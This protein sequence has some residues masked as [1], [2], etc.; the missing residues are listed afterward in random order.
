M[1]VFALPGPYGIGCFSEEA[2][3]FADFLEEAGQHYWQIL[4]LGPTGYGDSP[5]SPFSTFAGNPYFIDLQYFVRN[6]LLTSA[7]CRETFVGREDGRIDYG[8]LYRTRVPLM[9]EAY[10]RWKQTG[11]RCRD[12]DDYYVFREENACWL[13][14]YAL[15]MA[16]K[17]HYG[18][19]SIDS[20]P[21]E[22]RERSPGALMQAR[23]ELDEEV[24][25]QSFVQY[26][27]EKQWMELKAYVNSKGIRIIGDIPIYVSSDSADFWADSRLFIKGKDGGKAP[28][29]GVPPD[30]FSATGQLW[31]N[32]LYDW[33]KHR[34]DGYSWWLERIGRCAKI[35][36]VLRI[37]HF[38]G[39]DEYFC[40]PGDADSAA[41]GHWEKGPGMDL[42]RHVKA[43]YPRLNII[44]E[45]LGYMSD[46]VK[47]L[48]SDTG[49]PNMKVLEFAFDSR[50]VGEKEPHMPHAY[51]S[52][53]VAYTGTHDNET[54]IQWLGSIRPA[55]KEKLMDYVGAEPG[56][57]LQGIAWK[58]IRSLQASHAELCV[59][60]AWDWI[61][62]GAEARIN[63]PGSSSG[64]WTWRAAPDAFDSTLAA[65][66]RHLCRTY[67]R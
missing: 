19:A 10:R 1:P 6:G 67:G 41:G 12:L 61:G 32:P 29:A 23:Q 47:K 5:Y 56:E 33:E 50:D 57:D 18:G 55:E 38:R 45:D 62:L 64:N 26:V 46:S 35:Y 52:N 44:A 8:L 3:R 11:S 43:A 53:C 4:P 60:P 58:V 36:D 34:A 16:L 49:F 59:I 63:K 20:W 37:D 31:G 17:E 9:R 27:F 51:E 14:D 40:I 25:I 28:V 15:F 54:L 66:I 7:E 42:F 30:G 65:R 22:I 21:R 13:D 48:V 24:R 2:Y 39:F